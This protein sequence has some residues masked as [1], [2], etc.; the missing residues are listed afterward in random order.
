[1]G[2]QAACPGHD[3][4]TLQAAAVSAGPARNERKILYYRNPMGLPDTSPTPKKD[5]MGMDYIPVYAG[6][7]DDADAASANQIRISTDK[8]QKLGVR[9]EAASLRSLERIVRAA[10]RIEP[11][12]R[13]QYAIAPKFEGYVERLLVNVTGQSVGKGQPLFEVY[14]P[15]LVSAQREYAIAIQ[16]VESLNNAGSETGAAACSSWPMRASRVSELGHLRRA[17]PG[18][19]E[20]RE[21][22]AHADLPLARQRHRDREEGRAGHAL[23][24]R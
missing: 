12:E 1:L 20:F 24:A 23:H 6:E 4:A 21:C 14:S 19:G 13:R 5:P 16:G 8:V 22:P 7:A 11:D 17:D 9:T 18:P 10:G 2:R 15:E 3:E